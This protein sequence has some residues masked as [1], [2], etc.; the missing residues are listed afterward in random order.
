MSVECKIV[1]FPKSSTVPG[2]DKIGKHDLVLG[3]VH[4]KFGIKKRDCGYDILFTKKVK[5]PRELSSLLGE[6]IDKD[7]FIDGPVAGDHIHMNEW[8]KSPVWVKRIILKNRIRRLKKEI[9][10]AL[11]P[12]KEIDELLDI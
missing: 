7:G 6:V 9:I 3:G 2:E 4:Y 12:K 5:V 10:A 8:Y 11:K 1:Q